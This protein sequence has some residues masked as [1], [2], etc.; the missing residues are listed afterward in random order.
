M[1]DELTDK[2]KLFVQEYVVDFNGKQ[3]AIRAGYS[4]KSA[5]SIASENLTKPNVAAAIEAAMQERLA[6][7]QV[8]ADYVLRRLVD[9][10]QMDVI[11]ILEEDGSFKHISLWPKIWRQYLAGLDMVEEFSG[12]GESREQ[13]GW[14]KKIK[15]PDKVKNL[16]L[17]GKHVAVQAWREKQSV[18][19]TSSDGSMSVGALLQQISGQTLKPK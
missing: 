8:D 17:L 11:D 5:A 18:D 16:E 1:S 2:L 14:L 9:I 12:H 7:T 3:A 15:W 13:T 6:R 10:D 19:H 4:E